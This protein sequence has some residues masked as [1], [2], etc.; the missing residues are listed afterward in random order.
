MG[1]VV[2]IV[3]T[4][5]EARGGDR[6]LDRHSRSWL[7]EGVLVV[8]IEAAAFG[9][10]GRVVHRGVI[11][12]VPG[13]GYVEEDEGKMEAGGGGGGWAEERRSGGEQYRATP[14]PRKMYELIG[15]RGG[16]LVYYSKTKSR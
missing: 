10:D 12:P 9:S 13:W 2:L 3:L 16:L 6:G 4:L 8:V 14:P 7:G 5:M 15:F 1:R 11:V